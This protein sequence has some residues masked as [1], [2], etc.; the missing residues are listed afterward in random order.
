M[1][2]T[3]TG[4]ASRARASTNC[5]SA[6][7]SSGGLVSGCETKVVT[8]PAAAALPAER[9]PSRWRA[10]VQHDRQEDRLR[11]STR[12]MNQRRLTKNVRELRGLGVEQPRRHFVDDP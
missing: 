10:A 9:Y 11:P 4:E 6:G 3:L 7:S 5:T 8:P 2:W 12:E 1:A